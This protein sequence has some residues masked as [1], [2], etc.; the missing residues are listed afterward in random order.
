MPRV[1]FDVV[2]VAALI[3]PV[4]VTTACGGG[5]GTAPGPSSPTS[6][7]T[8]TLA[9]S[10]TSSLKVNSAMQFTAT[11]GGSVVSSQAVWNS[12]NAAVASVSS[13]GLVT[14]LDVGQTEIRATHA[15]LTANAT[16]ST[17]TNV[18]SITI[19]GPTAF[20]FSAASP[21]KQTGVLAATATLLAQ[22]KCEPTGSIFVTDNFC[23]VT[24]TSLWQSSNTGAVTVSNTGVLTAV[25]VGAASITATHH[26]VT[27]AIQATVSGAVLNLTGTFAGSV[28][29]VS[30]GVSTVVSGPMTL[31]LTQSGGSL[32]GQLTQNYEP[33]TSPATGSV[34]GT[35]SGSMVTLNFPLTFLGCPISFVHAVTSATN[36][37]IVGSWVKQGG[38][39]GNQTS[40]RFTLSRQ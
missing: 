30:N 15:G 28:A 39:S 13:G 23:T 17:T 27:G 35:V 3:L 29:G 8:K 11:L 24:S 6:P 16:H 18:A 25:G 2:L 31:V 26:G 21:V 1:P 9:V 7:T 4:A 10:G 34:T 14:A 5:G 22:S 32:S 37:S 12:S 20:S 38:C 19:A 40:G 33:N 36:T